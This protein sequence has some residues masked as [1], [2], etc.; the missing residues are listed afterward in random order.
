V[1][2]TPRHFVPPLLERGELTAFPLHA[3]SKDRLRTRV[4]ADALGVAFD[5]SPSFPFVCEGVAALAD[6]V[7]VS[8]ASALGVA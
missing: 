3:C 1:Q 2:A 5:K 4:V 7:D 8:D 6:G